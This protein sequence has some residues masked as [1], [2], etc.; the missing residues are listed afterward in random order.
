MRL[1]AEIQTALGGSMPPSLR[2]VSAGS[3]IFEAY[4]LM[5]VIQAALEEGAQVTY[6]DVFGNT[7]T[8]FVFRTSPGYIYSRA[9]PYTH[10]VIAFASKPALE[11]HMGVRVVGKSGVL[12]ECDIAV[13]EQAEAETCRR[14]YVPPRSTKVLIAAECKF[15]VAALKLSLAREFLG[16]ADR[17]LRW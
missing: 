3:D 4:V 14:N 1:L 12:H 17:F 7:P 11:V 13:I 5:L 6:R 8:T 9:Q 2:A 10:G 16:V 15:Y